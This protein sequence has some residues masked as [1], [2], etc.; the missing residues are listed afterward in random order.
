MRSA[1]WAT[2]RVGRAIARLVTW[3][4][5]LLL[6][7]AL[8]AHSIDED[9]TP[10]PVSGRSLSEPDRILP[11][12]VLARV[13]L[14]RANVDL[15]RRYVGKPPPPTP[16][17]R[18][19]G[20]RPHEVYLQAVNLQR[21]AHRLAFEQVR[22]LG[23]EAIPVLDEVRPFDVFN[24]IDSSLSA[25]LT[26]K[27]HLGIHEAIAEQP[28]PESTTPSEVF[29]ATV[30]AGGE[31][32]HLLDSMT[33]PSDVFLLTTSAVHSAAAMHAALPSGP[34]LPLEPAF[35]PNKT[36]ADV[37]LRMQAC[38]ALVRAVAA[39]VGMETLTFEVDDE[40]A[41]R[42]TPDDVSSLA[43]LV[44]GELDHLHRA[45]SNARPPTAAYYPGRRYPSDVYQ[46][47]GYL[48]L[49]LQ[50]L[51]DASTK[52]ASTPPGRG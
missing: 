40:R 46:R 51:L 32:N 38:F 19:E 45:Y 16:I 10:P 33:T 49:I 6:T 13:E 14:L 31:I 37:Y 9:A 22:V 23:I 25:V 3:A 41:S 44:V 8:P 5:V 30:E 36:P 39:T 17:L 47:A 26:V 18:V 27:R 1:H 4:A 28:Q 12:D 29:N 2:A 34:N 21:R 42:V 7:P 35:E 48:E 15:L 50:D 11:A 20:A 43:A 24:V 52:A